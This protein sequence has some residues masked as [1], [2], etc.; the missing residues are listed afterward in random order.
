FGAGCFWGVEAVFK[1]VPGVLSTAVGYAGG[2]TKDPTYRDVC[3]DKTGHAEVVRLE[4]DPKK[5]AYEELLKVFFENHN[6]TQLNRQGPDVGTQYRS[7]IFHFGEAQ[8]R[9]AEKAK[10]ALVASGKHQ[11]PIVTAIEPAPTFTRAEEYHQ[12]YFAKNNLS[13]CPV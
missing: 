1:A 13:H 5:V 4:F 6:P 8:K 12:D 9:A 11:K 3:T 10:A 2:H 7:V